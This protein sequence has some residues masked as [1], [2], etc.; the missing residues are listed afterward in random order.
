[1]RTRHRGFTLI[2]L[3]VVIA[4]AAILIAPLLPAVIQAREAARRTMCRSHLRQIGVALHNYHNTCRSFPPF[5]ISRSG[6]GRRLADVNKGA[7]WL[8]L[9]LTYPEQ[10]ALYDQWN[11]NI[12]ASQNPGRSTELPVLKCHSD[13]CSQANFCSCAGGD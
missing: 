4:I 7:N 1:M 11:F 8:V 2:E 9:L 6:N 13:P 12:L 10:S 5:F 3:L